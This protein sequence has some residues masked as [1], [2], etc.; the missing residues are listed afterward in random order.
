[1]KSRPEIDPGDAMK[2]DSDERDVD[3]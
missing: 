2:G 3:P 1:M